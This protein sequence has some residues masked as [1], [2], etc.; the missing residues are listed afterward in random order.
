MTSISSS[1]RTVC[2][3]P[4]DAISDWRFSSSRGEDTWPGV[5]PRTI[6]VG[7]G[8]NEVDLSLEPV[9]LP[10]EIL[11]FGA[12]AHDVGTGSLQAVR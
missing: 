10:A 7:S 12:C 9:L 4:N 1:S 11:G 2:R 3:R 5:Q 6:A 8:A